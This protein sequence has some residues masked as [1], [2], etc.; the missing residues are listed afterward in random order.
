MSVLRRAKL[1]EVAATLYR[2]RYHLSFGQWVP[3]AERDARGALDALARLGSRAEPRPAERELV[4]E[5]TLSVGRALRLQGHQVQAVAWLGHA[6]SLFAEVVAERGRSGATPLAETLNLLTVLSL[7][8]RS[9]GP[10]AGRPLPTLAAQSALL[11][12]GLP[13]RDRNEHELDLVQRVAELLLLSGDTTSAHELLVRQEFRAAAADRPE[14]S[15][16]LRLAFTANTATAAGHLDE[17]GEA[18]EHAATLPV[19]T[20]SPFVNVTFL[21]AKARQLAASGERDASVALMG[22]ARRL[23]VRERIDE[24]PV[25]C[26]PVRS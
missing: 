26:H 25:R 5:A 12:S 6:A 15:R 3:R 19:V 20:A 23:R 18:L 8:M 22:R 9:A 1:D 4:A 2:V 14:H 24:Q 21:E 16:S 13:I 17:A 7:N 11:C 10:E